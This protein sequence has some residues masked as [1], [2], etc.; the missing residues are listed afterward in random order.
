MHFLQLLLLRFIVQ[1]LVIENHW[2]AHQKFRAFPYDPSI[3]SEH[4]YSSAPQPACLRLSIHHPTHPPSPTP[5]RAA[6]RVQLT[7]TT[8]SVCFLLLLH[9]LSANS[10]AG[11]A[12]NFFLGHSFPVFLT[13]SIVCFWFLICQ[14]TKKNKRGVCGLLYK[15]TTTVG[16]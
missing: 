2:N 13:P 7:A 1:L 15:I 5:L 6:G 10:D 14:E 16:W 4:W 9:F 8:S 11:V 3:K 12:L